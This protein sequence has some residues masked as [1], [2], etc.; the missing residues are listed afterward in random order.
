MKKVLSS[1]GSP[2][3]WSSLLLATF[4]PLWSPFFLCGNISN[5]GNG[6]LC[7]C[8]TFG[9]AFS[10]SSLNSGTNSRAASIH[11]NANN[12][13]NIQS[14]AF[15]QVSSKNEELAVLYS[16]K[17]DDYNDDDDEDDYDP[18]QDGVDSVSWLPSLIQNQSPASSQTSSS[19]S[20]SSSSK[21][22][23]LPFFPLGGI[24]YT[25]N[26]EH[27]LNI[28]EPRY[29][30]MYTDILMNGSKRFVVSMSHPNQDATFAQTG[31][32]F[33]LED[34]KEV[35]ELTDDQVKYICNHKVMNRVTLKKVLNPEVWRTRETYLKVECE[36]IYEDG[37]EQESKDI[38][39]EEEEEEDDDYDGD[40]DDDDNNQESKESNDDVYNILL[41]AIKPKQSKSSSKSDPG[42]GNKKHK[43]S[44]EE[45][46][47][48]ASFQN[49]VSKQHELEEDVRFT[50]SSIDSLAVEPGSGENGLWQ[51]IRLWQSF[52]DQ[53]LVARQNDMQMEF[54]EKLLEFLK[55]EKGISEEDIP[56]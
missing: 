5:Q 49:L 9:S 2:S 38:S 25:P 7:P 54:Q 47:L 29:R 3:S 46:T 51:T 43:Y 28:F 31:V 18:L 52:I 42:A 50:R 21:T 27:V 8:L 22:E 37:D 55:K 33:Y 23:I 14:R 12:M 53:R 40:D 16:A 15:S 48:I 1:S 39:V 17:N 10:I 24:V 11:H 36:I 32:I 44:P 30:Q 26:S 6:S 34:L 13:Y 4:L 20:S 19:P 45:M 41:D 35:S 56:R